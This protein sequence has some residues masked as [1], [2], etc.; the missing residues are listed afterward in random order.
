MSHTKL[1]NVIDLGIKFTCEK[2]ERPN[3][4]EE[5]KWEWNHRL[6]T[7]AGYAYKSGRLQFSSALFVHMEPEQIRETIIHETCHYLDWRMF[8]TW[9][10]GRNW[11]YLMRLCGEKGN[12]CHKVDVKSLGLANKRQIRIEAKCGC[13][14]HYITQN[15]AT[16]MRNGTSYLCRHCN[17]RIKL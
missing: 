2:V 13:R 7:T 8:G 4:V 10:H 14:T 6:R 1:N 5:I 3:L 15:R 12:R 11:K 17:K 9:G 16:R